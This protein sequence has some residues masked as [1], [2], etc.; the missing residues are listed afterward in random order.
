MQCLHVM[1]ERTS[2]G[3]GLFDPEE[4]E[5]E[6]DTACANR[7]HFEEKELR[8]LNTMRL[9]SCV[10][11]LA[12]A[13]MVY[14]QKMPVFVRQTRRNQMLPSEHFFNAVQTSGCS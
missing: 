4:L 14:R 3:G 5:N 7:D 2:P 13:E 12:A 6:L 1:S 11:A 8:E 9:S 10:M